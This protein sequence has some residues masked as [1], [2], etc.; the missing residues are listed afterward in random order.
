MCRLYF[1]TFWGDFKG[2][3]VGR[4]SLLAQQEVLSSR[5]SAHT[6]DRDDHHD[7]EAEHAH[8]AEDLAQPGYP[9]HEAPWQLT[10]PLIFLATLSVCA[11]FLNPGFESLIPHNKPL[12]HWLDPVFKAATDGA[13][14]FGH[15]NDKEWA[16]KLELPLAFGGITAFAFGTALAWWKYIPKRAEPPNRLAKALPALYPFA[17]NNHPIA[18]LYHPLAS[19]AASPLP[20]PTP[21]TPT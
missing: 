11:G 4:P 20:H 13:V 14:L 1:M 15:G 10:V 7:S 19:P 18:T 9:P 12:D 6:P 5:Q 8:P 3:T 16:E 21:P 2:W 17:L